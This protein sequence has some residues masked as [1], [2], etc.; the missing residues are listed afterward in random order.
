MYLS[1]TASA[2]WTA[3]QGAGYDAACRPNR[4][5]GMSGEPNGRSVK[6]PVAFIDV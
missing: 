2:D 4:A 3:G 5:A 1:I 6:T